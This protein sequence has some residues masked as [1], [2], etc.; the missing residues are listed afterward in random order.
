MVTLGRAISKMS[1]LSSY[2][3]IRGSTIIIYNTLIKTRAVKQLK[4]LIKL[5]TCS[6]ITSSKLIAYINFGCESILKNFGSNEL[7]QM[8]ESV[9]DQHYRF[10]LNQLQVDL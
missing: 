1:S 4:E 2:C 7:W 6:V 3:L 5:I 8:S 9:N 10:I